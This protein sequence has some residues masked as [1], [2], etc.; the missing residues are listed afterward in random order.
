MVVP[1][2]LKPARPAN[3]KWRAVLASATEQGA[4]PWIWI[5]APDA[6]EPVLRGFLDGETNLIPLVAA[7]SGDDAV[8]VLDF[9]GRS[10]VWTAV[11]EPYRTSFLKRTALAATMR[12]DTSTAMELPL[13][14]AVCSSANLRVV[15]ALD[16]GRAI[17]TLEAF[18]QFCTAESAI[19]IA[20]AA[21]LDGDSQRFGCIIAANRWTEAARY[22]AAEVT[23][24]ADFRPAADECGRLLSGWDRLML[25]TGAGARPTR[26]ELSHGLLDVATTLYPTGPHC[27]GLWERSGGNTADIPTLGTGRDQW[28]QAIRAITKGSTG[29]PSAKKLLDTMISDYKRNKKLRKL[30]RLL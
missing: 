19:E 21:A 24:R 29:A 17:D 6:V 1:E 9:P 20:K 13:I 8:D 7:L 15:A 16:M 10:Q 12:G 5:N 11:D 14:E 30:R 22:L 28:T 23:R 3:P 26:T 4:N 27:G 2:A 18:A 25:I